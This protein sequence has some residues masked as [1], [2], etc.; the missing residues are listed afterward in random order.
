MTVLLRLAGKDEQRQMQRCWMVIRFDTLHH[1]RFASSE[2]RFFRARTLFRYRCTQSVTQQSQEPEWG[3]WTSSRVRNQG[4][5]L[6]N[7]W[8]VVVALYN[9]GPCKSSIKQSAAQ[10]WS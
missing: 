7:K 8:L 10:S 3:F 6:L 9:H 2:F 1:N 5:L 4:K